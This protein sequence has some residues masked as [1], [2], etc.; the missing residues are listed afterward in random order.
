MRCAHCREVLHALDTDR[1][2]VAWCRRE[3][4]R[5][6]FEAH[7]VRCAVCYQRN[8]LWAMHHGVRPKTASQS[9]RIGTGRENGA[10]DRVRIGLTCNALKILGV[11]S[12]I[13]RE[14]P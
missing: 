11:V 9:H 5:E 7:A 10:E 14:C 12:A 13:A 3:V 2:A 8:P 1:Y 6:C 4:H